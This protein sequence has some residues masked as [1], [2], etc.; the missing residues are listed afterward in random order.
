[1]GRARSLMVAAILGLIGAA[2]FVAL[3][4]WMQSP[5]FGILSVFILMNCW[6]KLG[7]AKALS[8][9]AKL[10]RREWFACPDARPPRR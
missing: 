3:A 2:G 9:L 1:M 4:V 5:W 7:Q 8:R 6:R 10:P